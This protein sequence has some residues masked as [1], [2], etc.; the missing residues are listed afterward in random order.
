MLVT[1]FGVIG[2]LSWQAIVTH[3]DPFGRAETSLKQSRQDPEADRRSAAW[4]GGVIAATGFATLCVYVA[5]LHFSTAYN[6]KPLAALVFTIVAFLL[7]PLGVLVY[8]W[9]NRAIAAIGKK[10]ERFL[11]RRL[12]RLELV[13]MISGVLLASAF[14]VWRNLYLFNI[15]D[16][17]PFILAAAFLL[18][19]FVIYQLFAS[20]LGRDLAAA[21][22]HYVSLG[23]WAALVIVMVTFT[24]LAF[25]SQPQ[26][27]S[28]LR[29]YSPVSKPIIMAMQGMTDSDRDGFSSILRGGD[30]NDE[31]PFV[32]PMAQEIPGNSIDDD[33]F[34]G[35]APRFEEEEERRDAL[36]ADRI[37]K[38]RQKYN[39]VL[40]TIDAFRADHAGWLGYPRD[41]TPELD[42]LAEKSIVFRHAYAQAPTT[43]YSLPVLASG[44]YPTQI[45]WE[46]YSN[47]PKVQSG[48]EVVWERLKREGYMT[49]GVFS[50][51][52]FDQRNLRRTADWWD[53]RAFK[54]RGHA[55]SAVTDDLITDQAMEYLDRI[56]NRS[57]Q[58]FLWLH[59]FDP[60]FLYMKHKGI[61]FGK[62]QK[63]LYDG[64]LR[65]TSQQIARFIDYFED[66]PWYDNSILIVTADHGEE[67]EEHG[68]KYHGS[69]VYDESVRVPLLIHIPGLEPRVVDQPVSLVDIAPTI[70]DLVGIEPASPLQGRSLAS[71]MLEGRD[72]G[73]GP[74]YIEKL[75][76]PTF[77]WS[78]QALVDNNWKLIFRANEQLFELYDLSADPRETR[79]LFETNP[80]QAAIMR[81]K[82]SEFRLRH[83]KQDT[84]WYRLAAKK[85]ATSSSSSDTRADGG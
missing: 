65:F 3:V 64:E 46:K 63:D 21:F 62:S 14:L 70:Y 33:C 68:M 17:K 85:D 42:K 53:T 41:T 25:P 24:I 2:G 81:Q 58:L 45:H 49:A 12:L 28:I 71:L 59:Y 48:T 27:A 6:N 19:H 69:Q 51:W 56:S 47:F 9:A 78:M 61:N 31:D 76:S 74:V 18:T 7:I 20:P 5:Q 79:N 40:I 29:N 22:S 4:L 13:L 16:P 82:L 77:P 39:V 83:L 32:H 23:G 60:H 34:G 84:G 10:T 37:D 38:L 1:L 15:L 67:F 54:M 35:D 72:E 80:E 55:E 26:V 8:S 66:S 57:G 11:A 43:A 30:C 50:Y 75:Q 36:L 73:R 52:Y 44:M